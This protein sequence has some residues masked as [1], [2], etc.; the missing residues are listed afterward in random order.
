M[1]ARSLFR[2]WKRGAAV[3]HSY[4]ARV[5]GGPS[6]GRDARHTGA[7][8]GME[9]RSHLVLQRRLDSVLCLSARDR[10]G[11]SRAEGLHQVKGSEV[12]APPPRRSSHT[13]PQVKR[14]KRR[15]GNAC[16]L[17]A[18]GGPRG[19]TGGPSFTSSLL[20]P[21]HVLR[22]GTARRILPAVY[23]FFCKEHGR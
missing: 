7:G 3:P 18:S 11:G 22:C 9:D 20:C 17:C 2:A 16:H 15:E 12:R 5:G 19:S 21:P 8:G 14:L 6:C 4:C 1:C 10:P 23:I 13:W